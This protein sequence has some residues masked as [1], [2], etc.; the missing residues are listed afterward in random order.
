MGLYD[1]LIP[2]VNRLHDVLVAID[3]ESAGCPGV[4]VVDLPSIVVVGS[5]SSGKSSVLESLVQK[6]FL[7]RGRDIVTRRPLILQLVHSANVDDLESSSDPL[8]PERTPMHDVNYD[9][10]TVPGAGGEAKKGA[11]KS[12]DEWGEFGHLP[13]RK[14][15]DFLQIRREIEE[16]T[17]RLAG[18]NKGISRVPIQLRIY[19]PHVLN[20]TLI[21]LPGITKIPVGEQPANIEAVI[22]QLI[23]DYASKPNTVI[24]AVTPANSDLANSDALKVAREADPR[25]VRTIGVL[26]K[27]D[28][29]DAGTHAADILSNRGAFRLSLGF[30]GVVCRSQQDINVSKPIK[31]ALRQEMIFFKTHQH[32]RSISHRCGSSFLA[33]ELNKVSPI[34]V[35]LGDRRADPASPLPRVRMGTS[36]TQR[37]T[38][39]RR[40][41]STASRSNCRN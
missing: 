11:I 23:M 6:D 24:L 41:C 3:P 34:P 4:S 17:A 22:R 32:Y 40:F 14:F 30:V 7:P 10:P 5:Q 21:D 20:L 8:A 29:M 1:N 28:L 16:E 26:T 18:P 35:I 19:S 25:G 33:K 37:K 12:G 39:M 27:L 13:G 36:A 38:K 15:A 9:E 31:E 2:V